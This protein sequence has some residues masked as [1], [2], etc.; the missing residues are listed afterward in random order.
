MRFHCVQVYP[1][2]LQVV[3]RISTATATACS[4]PNEQT[5]GVSI[6]WG[7]PVIRTPLIDQ[8]LS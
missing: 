8:K 6:I 5:I 3:E 4:G 7:P 2:L 1:V